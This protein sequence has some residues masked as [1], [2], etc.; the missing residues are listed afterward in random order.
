MGDVH[1]HAE[2]V[3]AFHRVVTESGDPRNS[4]LGLAEFHIGQRT[5]TQVV[6]AHVHQAQVAR[7]AR[8]GGVDASQVMAQR[9][10]VLDPDHRRQHAVGAVVA[11]L[12]GCRRQADALR[13]LPQHQFDGRVLAFG[14]RDGLG[15][16]LG[17]QRALLDEDHQERRIEAAALHLRQVDQ[18]HRVVA[19]I[20]PRLAHEAGRDVDVGIQRER[21]LSVQRWRVRACAEKQRQRR[22]TQAAM[23]FDTAS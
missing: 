17:R 10:G 23:D 22:Q 9:I 6:V 16:P 2:P 12:R 20:E 4:G 1:H 11:H 18:Q 13:I 15:I 7:A 14:L 19:H 5:R 3:G 8:V 21:A